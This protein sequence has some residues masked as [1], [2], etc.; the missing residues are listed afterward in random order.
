MVTRPVMHGKSPRRGS[1]SASF[2][3]ALRRS[4][5]SFHWPRI[6]GHHSGSARTF[7]TQKSK[8]TVAL[9]LV[10]TCQVIR[11][12]A[13][14]AVS[15]LASPLRL[16]RSASFWLRS[17]AHVQEYAPLRCSPKPTPSG[18]TKRVRQN[19]ELA[20]RASLKVLAMIRTLSLA[21][22]RRMLPRSPPNRSPWLVATCYSVSA[23]ASRNAPMPFGS[24]SEISVLV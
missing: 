16:S 23:L 11:T 4:R 7:A 5:E 3:V 2:G 21:Q 24:V 14:L 6:A 20:E 18:I 12:R 10:T 8:G 19:I 15:A 13:A 17:G 9:S 1:R 22:E